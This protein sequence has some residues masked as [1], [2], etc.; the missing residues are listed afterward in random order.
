[1]YLLRSVAFLFANPPGGDSF[2]LVQFEICRILPLVS[3]Y[4]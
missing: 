2:A 3:D 4:S 1:M